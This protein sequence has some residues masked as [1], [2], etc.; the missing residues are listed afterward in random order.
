MNHKHI[1]LGDSLSESALPLGRKCVSEIN[2]LHLSQGL[3]DNIEKAAIIAT[4]FGAIGRAGE[5]SFLTYGQAE[6]NSVYDILVLDW[7][8]VKTDKQ[9]PMPFCHDHNEYSLCFY[10]SM[11]CYHLYGAGSRFTTNQAFTSAVEERG[12]LDQDD[13]SLI[14]PSLLSN[15]P[16]KVKC[17]NSYFVIYFSTLC[18]N[19]NI[20]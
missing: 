11:F 2:R 9:A 1:L 18:I 19:F 14:F 7:N 4:T 13:T 16:Q 8:E 3:V 10:F 12:L 6:W 17:I 5:C 15:A 20:L